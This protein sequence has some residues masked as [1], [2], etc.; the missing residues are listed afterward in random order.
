ML[1]TFARIC[2]PLST[3]QTIDT[4]RNGPVK[5]LSCHVTDADN[6]LTGEKKSAL[7]NKKDLT[8]ALRCEIISVPVRKTLK[9]RDIT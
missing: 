3:C 1:S 6:T 4:F 8:S 5:P 7:F 2:Q 9:K